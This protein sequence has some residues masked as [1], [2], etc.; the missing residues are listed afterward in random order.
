MAF[1]TEL[2]YNINND[3]LLTIFEPYPK[4]DDQLTINNRGDDLDPDAQL[5]CGIGGL[6]N[7][8]EI[9]TYEDIKDKDFHWYKLNDYF[10]NTYMQEVY[11]KIQEDYFIGR[12]RVMTMYP[13][14]CYSYHHDF[15][16]RLHIPLITNELCKFIDKDWNFHHLPSGK[17]YLV[18]TTQKHT[19]ANFSTLDR[20]HIVMA[21]K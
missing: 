15:S 19:A 5:H 1:I 3:E 10:V 8:Y 7:W 17:A 9:K 11:E 14:K 13:G 12:S 20:T 2:D 6:Q 18:D 21:V 4:K 16:K